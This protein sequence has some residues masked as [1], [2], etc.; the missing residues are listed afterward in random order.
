MADLATE[1]L[2]G[3]TIRSRVHTATQKGLGMVPHATGQPN[4]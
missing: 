4:C 1:Q 3:T 2:I